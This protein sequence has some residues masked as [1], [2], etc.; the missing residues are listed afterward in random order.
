MLMTR[1][2]EQARLFLDSKRDPPGPDWS[3]ARGHR[4]F[5]EWVTDRGVP[6]EVSFGHDLDGVESGYDS[7][8]WLVCHC[9]DNGIPL[10]RWRVHTLNPVGRHNLRQLL[11][12]AATRMRYDTA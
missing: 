6:D 5:M 10:P 8:K 2:T 4:E 11:E 7:A 9:W 3:V 1:P 12:S